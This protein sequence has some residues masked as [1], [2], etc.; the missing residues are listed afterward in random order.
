MIFPEFNQFSKSG[1]NPRSGVVARDIP[2][3]AIDTFLDVVM[4]KE[5]SIAVSGL[6]SIA[7]GNRYLPGGRNTL[8]DTGPGNILVARWVIPVVVILL[9]DIVMIHLGKTLITVTR[10]AATDNSWLYAKWAKNCVACFYLLFE[11]HGNYILVIQI[12]VH[13]MILSTLYFL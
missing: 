13:D 5:I 3:L 9:L 2:W 6:V 1:Q 12:S 11:S 10:M 7:C 4:K 8:S